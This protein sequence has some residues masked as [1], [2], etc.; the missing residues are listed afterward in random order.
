MMSMIITW[1]GLI[2]FVRE[3]AGNPDFTNRFISRAKAIAQVRH[4]NIARVYHVGK[5][6]DGAPYV[7]QAYVDGI[8]L[9]QRLEQLTQRN[10]PVNSIYTLKLVRQL[11]DALLLGERLELFHYDLQ[12][13]NIYLKNVAL[14]TDD[15][16]VLIDLYIPS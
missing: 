16:V 13:D 11:A 4:P 6:P 5:T 15:T 2:L 10:N 12:P 14:P 8:S 3:Y 7:A 1:Y 9:A